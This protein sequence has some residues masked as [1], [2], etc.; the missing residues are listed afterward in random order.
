MGIQ[1]MVQWWVQIHFGCFGLS[2]DLLSKAQGKWLPSA[3]HSMP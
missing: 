1:W 3:S 2:K